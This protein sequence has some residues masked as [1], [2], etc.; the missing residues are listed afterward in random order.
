MFL[1]FLLMARFQEPG[2]GDGEIRVD[3]TETVTVVNLPLK[4]RLHQRPYRHLKIEDIHL[5]ENG[6]AIHP[7]RLREVKTALTLHFL[8]DMST[9]N[10]RFIFQAKK[11]ARNLIQR[12]K[13][14]DRAKISFF[15]SSYQALT[16]YERERK[17]LLNKLGRLSPVGS[18]ALYDGIAGAIDELGKTSGSRVLILFSD[19]YDLLSHI[20]ERE[21]MAKVKGYGIPIFF[22]PLSDTRPEG[23]LLQQRRFLE[24]LVRE[25]GGTRLNRVSDSVR[26]LLEQ[27]EYQRSRYMI[28]FRPPGPENRDQWR[29]LVVVVKGC[30]D[31][32][33]EYRR[34]YQINTLP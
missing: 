18:T 13:K 8:F 3:F 23:L 12:M 19:G 11:V 34:A 9:S 30:P 33:V 32:Q 4:V 10:E 29:S 15:S 7:R 31:C 27:L 28:S 14:S 5:V 25:S 2:S 6:V 26:P 21:L 20:G 24:A 1:L 17:L 16:G 22:L